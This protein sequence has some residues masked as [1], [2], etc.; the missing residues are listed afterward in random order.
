MQKK[1]E[2]VSKRSQFLTVMAATCAMA[3]WI[4]YNIMQRMESSDSKLQEFSELFAHAPFV[5]G[6]LAGISISFILRPLIY[7]QRDDEQKESKKQ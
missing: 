2:Q 5:I 4:L 3:T 7:K 1:N 6:P